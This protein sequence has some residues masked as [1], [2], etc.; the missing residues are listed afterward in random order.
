V[1]VD[2]YPDYA[3]LITKL[4]DPGW[5]NSFSTYE[6][7]LRSDGIVE[8]W[9]V[10]PNSG[11]V[12]DSSGTITPGRWYMVTATYDGSEE[13]VY[14]NG[15]LD[16]WLSASGPIPSS[17]YDL[18]FGSRSTGAPGEFLNGT[19][20]EVR[21]YNRSLSPDEVA[22]LYDLGHFN[23]TYSLTFFGDMPLGENNV[24]Y[25]ACAD[26]IYGSENCTENRSLNFTSTSCPLV[27]ESG[28][29][30][31][32]N[33][34]TGQ[35][36]DASEIRPGARACVK[37]ITS[38]VVFDCAGYNI[39]GTNPNGISFGIL[40][41]GSLN[42]VTLMNCPG[43]SNY[44]DAIYIYQ[45]NGTNITN[46]TMYNNSHAGLLLDSSNLT[47]MDTSNLFNNTYGIYSENS[48]SSAVTNSNVTDNHDTGVRFDQNSTYSSMSSNYVCFNMMDITNLNET[49]AGAGDRC[50]SFLYWSELGHLGCEY[51]CT[52]IWHRFFGNASGTLV[53]GNESVYMYLWNATVVNIFFTDSDANVS[54]DSLQ[55]IGRTTTNTSS[56]NDFLELDAAFNLTHL[57]DNITRMYSTDGTNPKETR[58]YAIFGREINLIPVANST[59][60]ATVFRTGILWDMSGGGTEYSSDY[61]QSTAWMVKVNSS[62]SDVYGT[63]DF[64]VQLPYTLG[65]QTGPNDLV[66]VYLELE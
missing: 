40:L 7:R 21:I 64:L 1:K 53:L 28:Y 26:D 18:V 65:E 19:M 58:D 20:D 34:Y 46:S 29:Y 56:S 3:H 2:S 45:S 57:K 9:T 37:I 32:L 22:A 36:N 14:I 42:N 50:D 15:V 41:N 6:L 27:N 51:T 31:M 52:D 25:Y 23:S 49:N 16:N 13:R 66:S 63:Y 11:R 44:T 62:T 12:L 30:P 48:L 43:I 55:A 39:T 60:L 61:N 35:G 4:A 8:F 10:D 5:G 54:W 47:S 59:D 24:T 17:P 33:N 38:D